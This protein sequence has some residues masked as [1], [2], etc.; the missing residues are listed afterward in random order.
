[1]A[2]SKPLSLQQVVSAA[3]T[4]FSGKVVKVWSERDPD[5]GFIVTYS[6]VAV[7]DAVRGVTGGSFTFKQYGGSYNG[8]NIYLADMSYFSEGEEVVAF[9]YPASVLGLTSPIGAGEGKL[10]IR[11]DPQS[12][13]EI[14]FGKFFGAKMVEPSVNKANPSEWMTS[15]PAP[16][17]EYDRFI[18]LVRELAQNHPR[19]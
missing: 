10:A 1:M 16:I 2:Q 5:S 7:R 8:L 3:G 9:L 6:T 15:A 13:K 4:I 14:V 12:G 18:S 19:Q 17:M 11:R